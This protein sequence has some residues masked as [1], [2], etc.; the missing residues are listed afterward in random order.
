MRS[1]LGVPIVVRGE[2]WGNI[3]L[4]EKEEGEEFDASDGGAR[5]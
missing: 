1:F 3:Y 4:S 2:A 5:S